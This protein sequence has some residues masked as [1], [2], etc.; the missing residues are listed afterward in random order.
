MGR[1]CQRC[2]L[3]SGSCGCEGGTWVDAPKWAVTQKLVGSLPRS[4]FL[5]AGNKTQR[6]LFWSV[7]TGRYCRRSAL[8]SGRCGYEGERWVD[9]AKQVVTQHT[10]GSFALIHFPCKLMCEDKENAVLSVLTGR[11][12]QRCD[13]LSGRC[14][15]KVEDEL[16]QQNE[17]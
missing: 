14:G 6:M 7:K 2:A 8:L 11:Y 13:L 10:I 16:M 12:C 9:V 17:L 3:L 4:Y 1:Y 5:K 15:W